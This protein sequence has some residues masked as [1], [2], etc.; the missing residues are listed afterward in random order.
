M[1]FSDTVM[2][3]IS[4]S[5]KVI[6]VRNYENDTDKDFSIL[7]RCYNVPLIS[8]SIKLHP[9]CDNKILEIS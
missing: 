6:V 5:I 4:W 9:Y 1:K 3:K 7:H 8:H 2:I